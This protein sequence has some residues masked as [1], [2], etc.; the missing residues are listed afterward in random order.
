MYIAAFRKPLC[1]ILLL[2]A[3]AACQDNTQPTGAEP[4]TLAPQPSAMGQSQGPR[5]DRSAEAHGPRIAQQVPDFGG[6]FFDENGDL[7]VWVRNAEVHGARARGVVAQVAGEVG[8]IPTR[9]GY[10][11]IIRQ[12]RYGWQELSDWRDQIEAVAGGIEGVRWVDLDER[13]NR[14]AVGVISA[15]ARAQVRQQADELG[16]ATSALSIQ[17][18]DQCSPEAL[19]CNDPCTVNPD[20]PDCNTNP[21]ELNPGDPSCQEPVEDVWSGGEINASVSDAAPAQDLDSEFNVLRGGIRI[22]NYTRYGE[23]SCSIGAVAYSST[24]GAVFVTNSHC[25]YDQGGVS[26]GTAGEFFQH[27][28]SQPL[29]VGIEVQDPPYVLPSGCSSWSL[30]E[31]CYLRRN[32]DA[33]VI[34][35]T[36]RQSERGTIARP[37]NRKFEGQGRGSTLIDASRPVLR[38]VRDQVTSSISVARG[39]RLDKVGSTTGWTSGLVQAVCRT[40]YQTS[41]NKRQHTC[42]NVINYT[43]DFG[44]S[45]APVFYLENATT[46]SVW[47]LGF[48]HSK[49][50][51][52]S[53]LTQV[54]RDLPGLSYR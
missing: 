27:Y 5:P 40:E 19:D 6:W 34:R 14:I 4:H 35:I 12:G 30:S 25:T 8:L 9:P 26:T 51:V 33:A 1:L 47:L 52:Y 41:P 13:I 23:N 46:G 2:S 22:R 31:S 18:V 42:Q 3:L 48:H 45:G 11:I 54:A 7:N 17:P 38:I 24:H 10:R 37:A 53:P 44:D 29:F 32:S 36:N 28:P 20:S 50:A 21:C 49:K 15:R 39:N 43:N 16:I